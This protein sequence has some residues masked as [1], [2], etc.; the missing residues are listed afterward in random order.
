MREVEGE[1]LMQSS[2]NAKNFPGSSVR[3][4]IKVPGSA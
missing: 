3:I 4:A 2:E 1:F